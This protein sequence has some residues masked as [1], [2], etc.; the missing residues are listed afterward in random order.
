MERTHIRAEMDATQR[1]CPALWDSS[2]VRLLDRSRLSW[3]S[4]WEIMRRK[5]THSSRTVDRWRVTTLPNASM[6]V[7]VSE[8]RAKRLVWRAHAVACQT[9]GRSMVVVASRMRPAPRS[10]R[11]EPSR[12]DCESEHRDQIRR[13]YSSD[14]S[15]SVFAASAQLLSLP[16]IRGRNQDTTTEP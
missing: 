14:G 3:S 1:P 11:N 13:L 4:E 9:Q 7:C 16:S 15:K 6:G 12:G 5:T 10:D 8:S 2:G